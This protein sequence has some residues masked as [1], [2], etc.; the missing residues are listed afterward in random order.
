MYIPDYISSIGAGYIPVSAYD[1]GSGVKNIAVCRSDGAVISEVN[2]TGRNTAVSSEKDFYIKPET[3]YDYYIRAVDNVGNVTYSGKIVFLVPKAHTVSAIITGDNNG[4]NA[5]N[6]TA[7]VYG[8]S[9]EIAS[10]VIMSED[11]DNPTKQRVVFI[12]KDVMSQTLSHGLYTYRH[13]FNP[14]T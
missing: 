13:S 10:L 2:Y 8:G 14:R 7:D 6:I 3:G 9:S 11:I 12:N 1:S 4:Y 5:N